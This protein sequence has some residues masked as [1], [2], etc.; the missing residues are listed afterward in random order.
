MQDFSGRCFV[1]V[2]LLLDSF[3]VGALFRLF[4]RGLGFGCWRDGA[5]FGFASFYFDCSIGS[6]AFVGSACRLMYCLL[7]WG[8]LVTVWLV[9]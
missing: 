4:C 5:V 9:C 6:Y 2:C 7:G 1:L 8:F 3:V